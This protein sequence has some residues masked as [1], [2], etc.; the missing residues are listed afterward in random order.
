MKR[1]TESLDR[2]RRLEAERTLA[3]ARKMQ[4][5]AHPLLRSLAAENTRLAEDLQSLSKPIETAEHDLKLAGDLFEKLKQ[6]FSKTREKV[7]VGLTETIG[8]LLRKQRDTLPD[9]SDYQRSVEVRSQAIDETQFRLYELEESRSAAANPDLIQT[10]LAE[11][12]KTL[13]P[14]DRKNLEK[15]AR[16]LLQTKQQYLDLLAQ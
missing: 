8:Q 13:S 4:V 15:A 14:E 6:H 2:A 11:A 10:I 3:A 9:P 1:L 12:P 16:E 7:A 5:E